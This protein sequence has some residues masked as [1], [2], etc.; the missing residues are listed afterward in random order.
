[1]DYFPLPY[2]D[3]LLYSTIA[4]AGIHNGILSPKELLF[5]VFHN[6]KV[7]ATPDLPGHILAISNQYP[8]SKGLDCES[9]IY[10][11]TL[12]PVYAPFV[13]ESRRLECLKW[14]RGKSYGAPHLALGLA[15]SKVKA[16]ANFR[17]C[18]QC[19]KAQ[20]EEYGEYFWRR[21]WQVFG[22]DEC[23]IHGILLETKIPFHD[24][25]RHQ[26]FAASPNNCH[27]KRQVKEATHALRIAKQIQILLNLSPSKSASFKQWTAYYHKLVLVN[28]LNRGEY[29]DYSTIKERV[30]KAWPGV[31]LKTVGLAIDNSQSCWLRAIF[32]KHRK[33]FSYLQHIVVLDALLQDSWRID[34]VI[35]KVK[36]IIPKSKPKHDPKVSPIST[37]KL[38]TYRVKWKLAVTK[39][40]VK[41]ARNS[42]YG[43]CYAWLYRHDYEWLIDFNSLFKGQPS[44]ENQQ[45]DWNKRDRSVLKLLRHLFKDAVG[46]LCAP[47]MSRNWFLK[48]MQRSSSIEKNL[49]KMPLSNLFLSKYSE[50][51]DEYQIRRLSRELKSYQWPE[52]QVNRCYLLRKAGLSE[53]RLEPLI[54]LFLKDVVGI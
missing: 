28:Q 44:S 16:I 7:I 43:G 12:F 14:M 5:E 39:L 51:T 10:K 41:D 4:R 47:R 38:K 25:H 30:L 6:S 3:E 40:G 22:V 20:L 24:Q 35:R 53:E 54:E 1:M 8:Y 26:F 11:H 32:R 31:W 23:L 42:G 34:N 36:E 27:I 2:P 52:E 46:E 37:W 19:L 15:A 33:S 49:H 18:P 45:V 29:I 50:S 17:Y 21:I 13:P 9:L 48:G